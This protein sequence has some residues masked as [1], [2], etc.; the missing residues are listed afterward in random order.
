MR[1]H[2][3]LVYEQLDTL[4]D[5]LIEESHQLI[6]DNSRESAYH[7]DLELLVQVIDGFAM[8]WD[9]AEHA[10][11]NGYSADLFVGHL[12]ALINRIL[13]FSELLLNNAED[14]FDPM[15]V[16]RLQ[17]IHASGYD[18]REIVEDICAR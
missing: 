3:D 4:I 5:L 1:T 18:L 10:L 17:H 2:V 6:A 12:R 15:Q 13:G 9:E 11:Q 8:R 16:A 14:A 7:D